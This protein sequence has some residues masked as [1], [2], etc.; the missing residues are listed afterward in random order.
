MS[1]LFLNFD[2][3]LAYDK[4]KSV[5][6]KTKHGEGRGMT[7]CEY[8][9]GGV[10]EKWIWFAGLKFILRKG[11]IEIRD[12]DY[13]YMI[14]ARILTNDRY[15]HKIADIINSESKE[16]LWR[17]RN[18][19]NY[20]RSKIRGI[21]RFTDNQYVKQ[22]VIE[23]IR[24]RCLTEHPMDLSAEFEVSEFLVRKIRA[25]EKLKSDAVR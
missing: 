2:L 1:D 14:D 10:F 16:T 11:V 15:L 24:S 22:D 9:G 4:L 7:E 23:A 6:G 3:L 25:E 21:S 17:N 12:M 13:G 20:F 8:S 18:N 5:S 19:R